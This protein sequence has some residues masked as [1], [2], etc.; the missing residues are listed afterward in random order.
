M[1]AINLAAEFK[2]EGQSVGGYRMARAKGSDKGE[3]ELYGTIY[4]DSEWVEGN[5]S[6]E[7][8]RRD[9]KSLGK[10]SEIDLRIDSDGGQVFEGW[11]IYNA[12]E[13]HTA[14][15]TA[16][17]DGLAASMA[18]V[19][20]MAADEVRVSANS[21]MM[22][23]RVSSGVLVVGNAD[24]IEEA[25]ARSAKV[26]RQLEDSIIEVYANRTGIEAA[27]IRA[28]MEAETWMQGSDAKEKGFADTLLP[29]AAKAHANHVTFA[30]LN[31]FKGTPPEISQLNTPTNVKND[32]TTEPKAAP[33]A[34]TA[35][36][37]PAT[38]APAAQ[39]VTTPQIDRAE[40]E[41]LAGI[42]ADRRDD[43]REIGNRFSIDADEIKVAIKNKTSVDAFKV[44]ILDAMKPAAH[45]TPLTPVSAIDDTDI[46][47]LRTAINAT[48]DPTEKGKLAAKIRA[49]R[50]A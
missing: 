6:A 45:Q 37:P 4:P 26:S 5:R 19:I 16:T 29:K 32:Q 1:K 21:W 24:E 9:L 18:S 42:E 3:I 7:S 50:A 27:E 46:D 39:V 11:G 10:V 41:R 31:H 49:L 12:L 48:T 47:S 13:Q 14:R 23:H 34:Q 20:A 15:I 40:V 35:P 17:V 25:A 33:V 38:P 2:K 28:M 36:E 8:F 30:A 22:I 43:I 44:A